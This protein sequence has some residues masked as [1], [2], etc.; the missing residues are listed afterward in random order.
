[1]NKP[2]LRELHY[3]GHGAKQ[4]VRV[5]CP[6]MQALADGQ[7]VVVLHLPP[8]S[9]QLRTTTHFVPEGHSL[10]AEH[11]DAAPPSSAQKPLPSTVSE[12]KQLVLLLQGGLF[13][14]LHVNAQ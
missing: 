7:S 9:G 6:F 4:K 10:V 13:V 12:Q 1:V 3:G 2:G 11:A 8:L 14:A 5:Q